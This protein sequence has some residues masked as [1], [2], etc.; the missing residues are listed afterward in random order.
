MSRRDATLT[1]TL[2][3]SHIHTQRETRTHF[4]HEE[5]NQKTL[6]R[7]KTRGKETRVIKLKRVELTNKAKKY[8]KNLS[9]QLAVLFTQTGY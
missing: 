3:D 2:S 9:A 4:N 8:A 7:R 1:Y 5:G 6:M